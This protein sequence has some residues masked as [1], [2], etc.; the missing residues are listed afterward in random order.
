MSLLEKVTLT[1]F[2]ILV[3]NELQ[4]AKAQKGTFSS[5]LNYK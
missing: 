1:N 5:W 4:M 2:L 3:I